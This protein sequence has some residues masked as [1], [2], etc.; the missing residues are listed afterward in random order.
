MADRYQK[1]LQYYF[2]DGSHVIFNKYTITN[3]V[4]SNKK[5]GKV[6]SYSKNKDGYNLCSVL[7]D[8]GKLRRIRVCRAIASCQGPPP[9][10]KHTADHIDRNPTNDTDDNIRWLC[11]TGQRTNQSRSDN[12]KTAYVI[13]RDGVEKTANVWGKH[14]K[15][16]KNSFGREYS[17]GIIIKY[18]QQ[19]KYGFSYKEYSDISGEVWKEI[20]GS[21]TKQGRWEISNMSRV[22]YVT[23]YAENVLSGERFCLTNGY[24]KIKIN[25]Q[26]LFCHILSFM[27]F[28]PYEYA[29]KKTGEMVLHEDDDRLDFRPHKL[30][31]GTRSENNNDA[32]T[33]GCYDGSR[34]VRVKCASYINGVLE[35]EHESQRAAAKYLIING[36]PNAVHIGICQVLNGTRKSAYGRTWELC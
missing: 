12:R 14:L 21:K 30:R 9:S 22:K 25:G 4:I 1:T 15:G 7:D 24:P 3:G 11:R 10:S 23:K 27:T 35:K 2:E 20:V 16:E 31:L 26:D 28:F 29:N 34:N 33:N 19:K 6:M 32:H 5:T 8:S 13:V 18:A 36:H 17:E